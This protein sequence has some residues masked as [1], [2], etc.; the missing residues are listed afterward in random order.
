MFFAK[1]LV[2]AVTALA[3]LVSAQSDVLAFTAL[4]LHVVAGTPVFLNYTGVP[5]VVRR[6]F[7]GQ[8]SLTGRSRSRSRFCVDR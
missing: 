8:A 6:L 7:S 1:S 3:S 5:G 2:L 4:P